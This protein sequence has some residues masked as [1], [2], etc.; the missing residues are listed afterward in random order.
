MADVIPRHMLANAPP[1]KSQTTRLLC[2]SAF[3]LGLSYCQEV[4]GYLEKE[5][6]GVSPE[7]GVDMGL[8]ANVCQFVEVREKRF[9]L[10]LFFAS[11]GGFFV[12][13]V[14]QEVG[15]TLFAIATSWL[16]FR[17]SYAERSTLIAGFRKENFPEFDAEKVFDAE[18]QPAAISALPHDAQ[19]LIVYTGFNPFVGAG[20]N[21]GGWS[22]TVDV[23]KPSEQLGSS[24]V[25]LSFQVEELY[26]AI[27]DKMASA[28]LQGLVMKDFYFVNGCEIRDDKEILPSIFGRPVQQLDPKRELQY[29][30]GSD[31]RIRHYKWIR[32][33]DWG[34]ELVMSYFLRCSIHGCNM[35]VEINRFLLTPL[36]DQ[37]RK[38]DA[39]PHLASRRIVGM[40]LLS[41]LS[42]PIYGILTPVV[43]LGRLQEGLEELFGT[44]ERKRR[45]DIKENLQFDYGA[46]QGLRQAFS[47]DR[48]AHYFQKADGDFYTKVLERVILSSIIT[49]L[50]EHHI[51]TSDLRE[52]Q[53]MI[54]NSG[55]IVQGGD[56]KAESLAVGVGAQAFKAPSPP[57]P[58][59]QGA[60]A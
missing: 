16:Y 17:K 20:T 12:F 31:S 49:F 14:S 2:A 51:D 9:Q 52:R 24:A 57:R 25:P 46:G 60:A 37:Y 7:L 34:Q 44:K 22:F 59:S 18:L 28:D 40:V 58:I 8:V 1:S 5:S 45:R 47:S 21:L 50:D 55:I 6:H 10:Y 13:L 36:S 27:S 33:H 38:I 42:G 48:F 23:S 54:L 30:R 4:L 11:V 41:L 43:L 26:Q 29:M 35:F 3:R 19:N 53:T 56:V 39:L 15:I 32:I